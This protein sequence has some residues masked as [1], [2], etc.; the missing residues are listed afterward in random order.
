MATKFLTCKWYFHYHRASTQHF[1]SQEWEFAEAN[2]NNSFNFNFNLNRWRTQNPRDTRP[3][4][5]PAFNSHT[6][7]GGGRNNYSGSRRTWNTANMCNVHPKTNN[8]ENP[9]RLHNGPACHQNPHS[10]NYTGPPQ[11]GHFAQGNRY[12]E[13][14]NFGRNNYHGNRNQFPNQYQLSG[15]ADTTKHK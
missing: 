8:W 6:G 3:S 5:N 14:H 1:I 10:Q 11:T 12:Q 13:P 7:R 4:W 15:A 2:Q 9:C